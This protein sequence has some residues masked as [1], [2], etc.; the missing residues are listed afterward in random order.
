M[1][2]WGVDKKIKPKEMKAMVRKRQQRILL[3][4]EKGELMF[5]LRGSVVEPH[6]IDRWMK[7][8]DIT[9]NA[10]FSPSSIACK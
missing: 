8:N 2:Q 7:R 9:Q 3:E 5:R 1:S 10:A 4:K 6:K